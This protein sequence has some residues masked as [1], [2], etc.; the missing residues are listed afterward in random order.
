MT[1][2]GHGDWG[3]S[4]S[5]YAPGRPG[6]GVPPVSYDAAAVRAV[7]RGAPV[8]RRAGS[9]R[10]P[11]DRL[12]VD[13]ALRHRLG[14]A[15]RPPDAVPNQCDAAVALVFLASVALQ[16]LHRAPQDTMEAVKSRRHG[17]VLRDGQTPP[18]RAAPP[19]FHIK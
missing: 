14:P 10:W 18:L 17:E 9:G 4:D 5:A 16:V 2:M 7:G 12:R 13:R 3:C 19:R 6:H 11:P 8:A 15:G 1:R